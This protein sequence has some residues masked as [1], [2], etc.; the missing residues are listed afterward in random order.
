MPAAI[1]A[2]Q[3]GGIKCV[4]ELVILAI[5]QSQKTSN[6]A[7]F[8]GNRVNVEKVERLRTAN[9]TV[10]AEDIKHWWRAE[11]VFTFC[12]LVFLVLGTLSMLLDFPLWCTIY[13]IIVLAVCLAVALY[14]HRKVYDLKRQLSGR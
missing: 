13:C 7:F 11:M 8:C 6:F 10:I 2:S 3:V 1:P 12:C 4:C 14:S 9:V 5:S